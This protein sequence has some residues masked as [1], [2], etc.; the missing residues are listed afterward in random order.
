MSN[1]ALV[2]TT[3]LSQNNSGLRNHKIDRISP[4]CYVGQ[5][6]IENM[7][8]WF[9]QKQAQASANYGI[10]RLGRIGLFVDESKRSWCTSSS[11]NDNRAVTIE[12]ASEK[13]HSY[14]M[15]DCVY[16]SL[17][18]LCV[19]ICQRNGKDTLLWFPD[20][21]YALNYEPKD[22]EMVITVHR[23]FKNKAC[24]GDWLYSRLG[25]LAQTVTEKLQQPKEEDEEMTQ[26]QFNEFMSNWLNQQALQEPSAWSKEYRDWAESNQYIIGD[27]KGRK[28]YKK[29]MTR[30]EMVTVLYRI[31]RSQQ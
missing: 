1:S 15:N 23:W 19:D 5:A 31:L 16:N 26:E 24:P 20:K 17:V 22:N 9:A 2:Q 3:I 14:E 29:F 28:M 6:T 30:E 11:A 27:D 25:A 4:H 10:D 7:G 12:C 18:N 13:T 8:L 21:N